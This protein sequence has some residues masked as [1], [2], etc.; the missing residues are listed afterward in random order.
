MLRAVPLQSLS[1]MT[2][3]EIKGGSVFNMCSS[4]YFPRKRQQSHMLLTENERY[5]GTGL[6]EGLEWLSN[7]L[8]KR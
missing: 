3:N 5:Q 1:H 2:V 8:S 7:E 6:Y 4:V